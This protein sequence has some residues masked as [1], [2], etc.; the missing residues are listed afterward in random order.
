MTMLT[1]EG[2][3]TTRTTTTSSATSENPTATC[4][5][6][7]IV[8]QYEVKV[9]DT[10]YFVPLCKSRSQTLWRHDGTSLRLSCQSITFSTGESFQVPA[11]LANATDS[12]CHD[13]T[14]NGISVCYSKRFPSW[15]STQEKVAI[16]AGRDVNP[17]SNVTAIA[18]AFKIVGGYKGLA[19]VGC[20]LS[21]AHNDVAEYY[22]GRVQTPLE[23][24]TS[25]DH[26]VM[27][28]YHALSSSGQNVTSH[29]SIWISQADEIMQ[30]LACHMDTSDGKSSGLVRALNKPS[31]LHI[32][33][34]TLASIAN[35]DNSQ[36]TLQNL[37]K[38]LFNSFT[39]YI[40]RKSSIIQ[41]WT[42]AYR[43]CLTKWDE[44]SLSNPQSQKPI[45]DD[46]DGWYAKYAIIISPGTT[47]DELRELG[48]ALGVEGSETAPL[49]GNP[50]LWKAYTVNLNLVQAKLPN[51]ASFVNKIERS[52]W[53][54]EPVAPDESFELIEVAGTD[55]DSSDLDMEN[56]GESD[57]EGPEMDE[58]HGYRFDQEAWNPRTFP[59]P[60]TGAKVV[61]RLKPKTPLR[62]ISQQK[63]QSIDDSDDYVFAPRAGKDSCI[64]VID[65]GFDLNHQV[66]PPSLRFHVINPSATCSLVS[67]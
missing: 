2:E 27:D 66:I 23:S 28:F 15:N 47:M 50:A 17:Y 52:V 41:G 57:E 14:S 44:G 8:P 5:A 38:D 65:T 42:Q 34:N 20:E 59:P 9:D 35:V 21:D 36:T 16:P 24:I 12:K 31:T 1:C 55:A 45:L 10:S 62:V 58:A 13:V 46:V 26:N 61:A 56:T 7:L 49:D 6:Q 54:G 48:H 33:I 29:G 43:L 11:D 19:E 60:A 63:G 51:S 32:G 22:F 40:G 67:R 3:G 53:D 64:F 39:L 4:T 25:S 37:I 18:E 30:N